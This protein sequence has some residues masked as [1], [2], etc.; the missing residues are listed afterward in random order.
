MPGLVIKDLPAK[1]HRKLKAQ[2]ARHHRSMTK[3]VLAL[4]ERALSEETRPQEVPP[5]FRGR[6][7]LTDEFIDR[8][9]REGR[10]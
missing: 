10:E 3:E 6:F 8:A 4:L 7:A 1:L 5:P 2:A 9:R